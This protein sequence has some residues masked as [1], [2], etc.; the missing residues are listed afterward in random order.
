MS[1]AIHRADAR[2]DLFDWMRLPLG[3]WDLVADRRAG[4]CGEV[5]LDL[6][7]DQRRTNLPL[8]ICPR[9]HSDR[10][11]DAV[12]KTFGFGRFKRRA[13]IAFQSLL[14]LAGACGHRLPSVLRN[15]LV[16]SA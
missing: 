1:S 6:D 12:T 9:G 7:R 14:G 5:D 8:P 15:A 11:S 16:R 13:F 10:L 3:S 2:R 4:T